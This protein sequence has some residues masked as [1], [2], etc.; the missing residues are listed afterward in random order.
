MARC[1]RWAYR[2]RRGGGGGAWG[3]PLMVGICAARLRAHCGEEFGCLL[4]PQL[5]R[6]QNG[7]KHGMEG[8]YER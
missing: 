8:V 7:P 6:R 4:V 2:A 1:V 3:P 5:A